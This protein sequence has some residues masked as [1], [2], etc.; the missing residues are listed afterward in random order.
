MRTFRVGYH[1]GWF[2]PVMCD[3]KVDELGAKSEFV[4]PVAI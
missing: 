4:K 2:A 1:A 3:A